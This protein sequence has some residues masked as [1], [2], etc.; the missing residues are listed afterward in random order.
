MFFIPKNII[1]HKL[2]AISCH[3]NKL[4]ADLFFHTK[5]R[6]IP[7]NVYKIVHTGPNIQ[8]GGLNEGLTK[9]A[10]QV[11]IAE[12]VNSEPIIPAA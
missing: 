3:I 7:I 2:F 8:D 11:G 1:D 5:Y 6:L 10:Y 9:A 4:T 12:K